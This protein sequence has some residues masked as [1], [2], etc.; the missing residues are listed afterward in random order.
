M[1]APAA[2]NRQTS[3]ARKHRPSVITVPPTLGYATEK[4]DAVATTP[5]PP[6]ATSVVS[7][8]PT[9]TT[10]ESAP[11][12]TPSSTTEN[13]SMVLTTNPPGSGFTVYSG[14]IAGKSLP[15]TAPLRTGTTPDSVADLPPGRYTLLFHHD[16]W[17]DDRAEVSVN[18]GESVPVDYS[19]PHG[20]ATITSTPDGAEILFGTQ[21]LGNAPLTVDL[22]LGKQKLVARLPNLPERSQ[23]VTIEGASTATVNFQLRAQTHSSRPK[24]TPTPSALDKLGQSLKHVFGGSKP[25]PTPRK[26][27]S[28]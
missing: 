12:P 7:V 20:S 1:A 9:T 16:G 23:T 11:S 8:E 2:S 18:A 10:E 27:H 19:F 3:V 17:P 13:A 26:R 5:P 4:Q 24:S 6:P 25:S 14:V 22:P 15:D 21:S 28:D